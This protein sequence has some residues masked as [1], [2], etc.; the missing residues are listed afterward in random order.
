[1]TIKEFKANATKTKY[2]TNNAWGFGGGIGNDFTMTFVTLG[3]FKAR[4]GKACYRHLHPN[5]Y[6]RFWI[7][8]NEVTK[9]EFE[10]Q[11][12]KA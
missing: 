10:T 2:N 6:S 11:L 7:N 4:F 3:T 1:M 8:D 9:K 12:N 5:S